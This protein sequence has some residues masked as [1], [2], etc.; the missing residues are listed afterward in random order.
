MDPI[1]ELLL[2]KRDEYRDFEKKRQDFENEKQLLA[3]EKIDSLFED[4][5]TKLRMC[6]ERSVSS[7]ILIPFRHMKAIK[8]VY[9][10]EA[11][12]DILK[13]RLETELPNYL[14]IKKM[15]VSKTTHPIF[16]LLSSVIVIVEPTIEII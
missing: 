16:G 5:T 15:Y 12:F 7:S 3:D 6:I 9:D 4:F 14:V 11:F 1:L 8:A 2:S 13:Q 10:N